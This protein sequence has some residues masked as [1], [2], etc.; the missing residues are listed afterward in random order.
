MQI[1]IYI[2]DLYMIQCRCICIM[3]ILCPDGYKNLCYINGL[4]CPE[5]TQCLVVGVHLVELQNCKLHLEAMAHKDIPLLAHTST[6][7]VNVRICKV[8]VMQCYVMLVIYLYTHPIQ[9]HMYIN[10]IYIYICIIH[11]KIDM[12]VGH[13]MNVVL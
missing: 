3:Y 6:Y 10:I 4:G 1:Y 5:V 8:N 11:I 13:Y 9:I 2:Y 12:L 7:K